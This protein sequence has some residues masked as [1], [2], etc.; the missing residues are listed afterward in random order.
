[1]SIEQQVQLRQDPSELFFCCFWLVVHLVHAFKWS[2]SSRQCLIFL[3]EL[4]QQ[5][6]NLLNL[7]YNS[8]LTGIICHMS[9]L[10]DPLLPT[11]SPTFLLFLPNPLIEFTDG[12]F[13]F[14]ELL[15]K[16]F[17][18]VAFLEE[19]HLQVNFDLVGILEHRMG[20]GELCLGVLEGEL[21]L[22]EN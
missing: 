17:T 8:L 7:G 12:L 18:D 11:I 3:L 16:L 21:E 6:T 5:I 20:L 9:H 15:F 14:F 4:L 1:M 2:S 19:F 13:L 22:F 10:P